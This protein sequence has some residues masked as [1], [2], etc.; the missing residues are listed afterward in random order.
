MKKN[1]Q[2][3]KKK[4]KLR[5]VT[6]IIKSLTLQRQSPTE[7][8]I[9]YI[10]P[11]WLH[12]SFFLF[13]EDSGDKFSDLWCSL[14]MNCYC[15]VCK[16]CITLLWPYGLYLLSPLSM[17]FSRQEYLSGL[18]FPSP[19]DLP[20][21]GTEPTSPALAGRFFTTEPPG[22]PL[23]PIKR[24]LFSAA[25]K[26]RKERIRIRNLLQEKLSPKDS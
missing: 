22:K 9:K 21:P 6:V 14:Y 11:K 19:G 17:G 2:F 10:P 4:L 25:S 3:R 20:N 16:S 1:Q 8:E 15:L 13:G 24:F 18:P 12:L 7:E 26:Q 5:Y 23:S